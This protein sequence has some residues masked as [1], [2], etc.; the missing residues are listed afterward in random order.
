MYLQSLTE[1]STNISIR[2]DQFWIAKSAPTLLH[3][4]TSH[5]YSYPY[6]SYLPMSHEPGKKQ[7]GL[8]TYVCDCNVLHT[9]LNLLCWW[10]DRRNLSLF[11]P[12]YYLMSS[13]SNTSIAIRGCL[14]KSC[15]CIPML[16][17]ILLY[18]VDV[19][20][21][22]ARRRPAWHFSLTTSHMPYDYFCFN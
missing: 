15:H 20:T 8:S 14:V 13:Y 21:Y 5:L 4:Q 9:L 6:Y 16:A 19:Y 17:F 2:E 3:Y 18:I 7:T 11:L 22:K 12:K 1:D 10:S